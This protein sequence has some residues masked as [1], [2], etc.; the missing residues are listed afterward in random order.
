MTL[1]NSILK[2]INIYGEF[3][4][5]TGSVRVT[6][7]YLNTFTRPAES[8][9]VFTL[10]PLCTITRFVMQVG[11]KTT[12]G[13]VKEKIEAQV[14]Y[15]KAKDDGK[16]TSILTKL[17]DSTYRVNIAGINP[18]EKVTIM[19][20]YVTV[21][22]LDDIGRYKFILPTN[23]CPKYHDTNNQTIADNVFA[24]V[25]Q[26]N[27][28]YTN[29]EQYKFNLELTFSS[30][31][32]I[33]RIESLT[34]T[35]DVT[36]IDPTRVVVK[37]TTSPSNGDFNLF[38]ETVPKSTIYRWTNP[39]TSDTYSL[40]THKIP[41]EFIETPE[42]K[43]YYFLLDRSGSMKNYNR[44]DDAIIALKEF[45]NEIDESS[46]F[47]IYSFG[48]S[49]EKMYSTPEQAINIRKGYCMKVV[50]SF[51]ADMGG[52]K[53]Y[54]CLK[55][56]FDDKP[57]NNFEKIFIFLTDGEVSNI[58][59][60]ETLIKSYSNVRIFSFGIGNHADRSL[61]KM[62]ADTTAGEY[63]G[64]NDSK[65]L[66]VSVKSIINLVNKQYYTNVKLGD[67]IYP[68][69]YPGRTYH[70]VAKNLSDSDLIIYATNILN[71]TVKTWD[72]STIAVSSHSSPII[73]QIYA[74][75]LIRYLEKKNLDKKSI[76]DII[77]LA[78][79]YQ[80]M[81]S[82]TSY[83]LVDN[84][85]TVNNPLNMI[86]TNVSH[87]SDEAEELVQQAGFFY[88]PASSIR[89]DQG[90][91]CT[92]KNASMESF[93]VPTAC[94][95]AASS[96]VSVASYAAPAASAGISRGAPLGSSRMFKS[97]SSDVGSK[98]ATD[99]R[100]KTESKKKIYLN[101]FSESDKSVG[102]FKERDTEFMKRQVA[103]EETDDKSKMPS[104]FQSAP[105]SNSPST[106]FIKNFTNSIK[107]AISQ[108][109]SKSNSD[110]EE[111]VTSDD[112]NNSVKS[113]SEIASK[114]NIDGSYNI[115]WSELLY[116]S[117]E[118]YNNDMKLAK[119]TD[120]ELYNNIIM[121]KHLEFT[122]YKQNWKKVHEWL[123]KYY[124]QLTVDVINQ[125]F[126]IYMNYLDNLNR[127]K[128]VSQT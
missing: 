117:E 79:T 31:E 42:P 21:L 26:E 87:H 96:C 86:S 78:V 10:T 102:I 88:R 9:Y 41:D 12:V 19:Y 77:N 58:N 44:I 65:D 108:M 29:K 101:Q 67:I 114:Q 33:R 94:R 61:I 76:D 66:S 92:W 89:R 48:D 80:I 83:I 22:E 38:I 93:F 109:V 123:L 68:S 24:K 6:Q 116:L 2:S 59:S 50:E 4:D 75:T 47:N 69:I 95:D 3:L 115:T 97:S 28:T 37:S 110:E 81:S 39:E 32:N 35:I 119:I 54:E 7:E 27:I 98:G 1:D 126:S 20:E 90:E 45:I 56:A 105:I 125:T 74:D 55:N 106:G 91:S 51:K 112:S 30:G 128:K 5:N 52:T 23:I 82:R 8:R 57:N 13:E 127:T 14:D 70:F 113:F 120:T 107:S 18:G 99:A 111:S 36:I 100:C 85:V 64:F 25:L 49:F 62:M 73:Q 122:I 43:N 124:P 17:N 34:N 84:D 11:D 16:K 103:R 53:I 60:I 121:Y 40:I 71:G 104:S 72:L 46:Y 15:Q 118:D 63:K